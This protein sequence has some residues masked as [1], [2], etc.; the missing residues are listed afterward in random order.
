VDRVEDRGIER[1]FNRRP[2]NSMQ[3]PLDDGEGYISPEN[4]CN[5]ATARQR[6]KEQLLPRSR[7]SRGILFSR[8]AVTRPGGMAP[9]PKTRPRVIRR[10]PALR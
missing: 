5:D 6:A 7:E 10:A 8:E 4:P 2:N 3:V 1:R 9:S